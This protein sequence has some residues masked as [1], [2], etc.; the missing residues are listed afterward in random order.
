MNIEDPLGNVRARLTNSSL[1][2][3]TIATTKT[4]SLNFSATERELLKTTRKPW[5]KLSESLRMQ[6][7]I[8]SCSCNSF[9]ELQNTYTHTRHS[10][11]YHTYEHNIPDSTARNKLLSFSVNTFHALITIYQRDQLLP[12]TITFTQKDILMRPLRNF[13]TP[14]DLISVLGPDFQPEKFTTKTLL[15]RTILKKALDT[16]VEKMNNA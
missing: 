14:P 8:F 13:I 3:P 5:T 11:S 16:E 10:A 2:V 6:K 1:T 4:A 12:P 9:P 7:K 15:L